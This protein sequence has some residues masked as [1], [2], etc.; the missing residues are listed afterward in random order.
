[1]NCN[2]DRSIVSSIVYRVCVWMVVSS[3]RGLKLEGVSTN[4]DETSDTAIGVFI[5]AQTYHEFTGVGGFKAFGVAS[6]ETNE[7]INTGL[8]IFTR[9][10]ERKANYIIPNNYSSPRGI[11]FKDPLEIFLGYYIGIRMKLRLSYNSDTYSIAKVDEI[12]TVIACSPLGASVASCPCRRSYKNW[13]DVRDV[14]FSRR[15]RQPRPP[16]SATRS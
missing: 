7:T 8:Q 9:N 10:G 14:W 4:I 2:R 12:Q 15:S 11:L 1:M 3:I 16:R 13:C 6:D 5:E